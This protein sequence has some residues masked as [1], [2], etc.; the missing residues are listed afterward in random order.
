MSPQAAQN[1]KQ[2]PFLC[3]CV[4]RAHA[5]ASSGCASVRG[6]RGRVKTNV[7]L[8]PIIFQTCIYQ[9][10]HHL[11]L[12]HHIHSHHLYFNVFKLLSAH[13]IAYFYITKQKKLPTFIPNSMAYYSL[14]LSTLKHPNKL[15][16]Q[17][18]YFQQQI[19]LPHFHLTCLKLFKFPKLRTVLFIMLITVS[20][21]IFN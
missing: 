6:K 18:L 5:S 4:W 7:D 19:S 10:H 16:S 21:I 11:Q 17:H 14:S 13:L 9:I 8:D 20:N 15:Y 3:E 1:L 2:C 12:I